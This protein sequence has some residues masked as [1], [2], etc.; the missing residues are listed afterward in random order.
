MGLL[1]KNLTNPAAKPELLP[2][3][4]DFK[5]PKVLIEWGP[6]QPPSGTYIPPTHSEFVNIVPLRVPIVVRFMWDDGSAA[7][8]HPD[9]VLDPCDGNYFAL[10]TDD[11]ADCVLT[12]PVYD[13]TV[14]EA[15]LDPWGRPTGLPP[16]QTISFCYTGPDVCEDLPPGVTPRP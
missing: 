1:N 3:Q 14:D 12:L 7:G 15:G 6:G 4:Y 9:D 5:S 16:G 10:V 13:A 11:N 8:Y 2:I